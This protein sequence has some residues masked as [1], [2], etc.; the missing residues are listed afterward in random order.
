MPTYSP[1]YQ[2]LTKNGRFDADNLAQKIMGGLSD[3]DIQSVFQ[4]YQ[5][6]LKLNRLNYL[7][8]KCKLTYL[9]L[10][11]FVIICK[12]DLCF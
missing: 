8:I 4:E 7:N 5:N 11:S 3:D 2:E 1:L 6:D 9:I 12:T 10:K